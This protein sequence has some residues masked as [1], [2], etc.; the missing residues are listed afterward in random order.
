M[1]LYLCRNKL[2]VFCS[3]SYSFISHGLY[4]RGPACL[5][6]CKDDTND[7]N[8]V[9]ENINDWP[10]VHENAVT[11]DTHGIQVKERV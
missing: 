7:W 9:L 3:C 11:E 4:C 2:L 5:H 6:N 1:L 8:E 10:S